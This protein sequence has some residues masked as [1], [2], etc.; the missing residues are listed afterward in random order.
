MATKT[1]PES[2][3]SLALRALGW[4]T[5]YAVGGVGLFSFITWKLIGA[6]SVSST[7][8]LKIIQ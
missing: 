8:K 4:G 2:G 1:L 6:K 3:A 7:S 5:F